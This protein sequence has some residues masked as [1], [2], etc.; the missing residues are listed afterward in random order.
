MRYLLDKN[1]VRYALTGLRHR[2]L[3]SLSPF[4]LGA[5]SF[6][7]TAISRKRS[8]FISYSSY[9]IL[10]Q[11]QYREVQLFLN[12]VDVLYPARYHS[13][14]TRRIRET[15]GLTREDAVIVAL[16][17]FG[18]NRRGN[19]LGVHY[20]LTYDQG[21]ING[22][23]DHLMLLNRRLQAMTVQ[24]R[25]PYQQVTLPRITTPNEIIDERL[26]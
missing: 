18:S 1:I 11:M 20:L 4:E 23:R 21:L 3:R 26:E 6:W 15:T 22:Y 24:L 2:H 16:A 9:A 10:Q 8:L 5:L 12:S 14:W 25:P 19:I 7:R 17:S 13:R